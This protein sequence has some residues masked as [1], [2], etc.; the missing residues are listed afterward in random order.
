MR[1]FERLSH[2]DEASYANRILQSFFQATRWIFQFKDMYYV[3]SAYAVSCVFAILF[4]IH[5]L[6]VYM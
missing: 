4:D 2:C 6:N 5:T 3:R 1:D